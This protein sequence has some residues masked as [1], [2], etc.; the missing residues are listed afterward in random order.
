[1]NHTL[2]VYQGN[3]LIF[4]SDGKWLHPLLDFQ[5]FLS[6][7][8]YN[9]AALIVND[10]IIGRAAALLIV[11]LG[12]KKVN[13]AILSK[14][15]KEAL[16]FHGIQFEFEQ[17]VDRIQCRTEALLKDEFNAERAYQLIYELAHQTS[18]YRS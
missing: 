3:N 8:N 16:E 14:P 1:M 10:K 9:R 13:A 2:E 15:G 11:H 12:I 17:L 18:Q 6:Q 4:F 7:H 5:K